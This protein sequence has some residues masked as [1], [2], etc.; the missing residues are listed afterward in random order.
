[1]PYALIPDGHK[2]RKVTKLQQDAISAKRTHDDT[3]ALLSNPNTP[4]VVGGTIAAFLLIKVGDE[5]LDKLKE[6]GVEVTEDLTQAIKKAT[7]IKQFLPD[8][9][10]RSIEERLKGLDL[11]GLA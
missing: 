5:I 10:L 3:V 8:L 2:L 11:R 9:S 1:M 6:A 7:D 4:L